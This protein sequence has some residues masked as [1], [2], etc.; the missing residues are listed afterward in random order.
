MKVTAGTEGQAATHSPI[1]TIEKKVPWLI[2]LK[3]IILQN[4]KTSF[5]ALSQQ[6]KLKKIR[7][8]SSQMF[9]G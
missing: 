1:I 5:I 2:N 3:N 9:R 7:M 6:T 8:Q 4:G